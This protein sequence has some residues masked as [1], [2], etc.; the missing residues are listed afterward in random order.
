MR[1]QLV[2]TINNREGL[3]YLSVLKQ[4]SLAR[5][6]MFFLL[7]PQS[8]RLDEHVGRLLRHIPGLTLAKRFSQTREV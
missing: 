7:Q 4:F 3:N 5:S 2:L 1:D 8:K 6:T